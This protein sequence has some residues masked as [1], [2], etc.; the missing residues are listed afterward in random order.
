MIRKESLTSGTH[1]KIESCRKDYIWNSIAGVINALEAVV[2]SMVVTRLGQ[3]SDAGILSLAFAAG[4]VMLT[5]GKFGVRMFQVTDVR[6]EYSFQL[7]LRHRFLTI[8]FMIL[9]LVGFLLY[10]GYS[11]GKRDAIILIAVIYMIEALEDCFWGKY[12]AMNKLYIGAQM[13]TTRW[14]AILAVF[15]IWML[16]THNMT[17]ALTAGA[18]TGL[19]V[20]LSWLI[21]LRK[22][23]ASE[24]SAGTERLKVQQ[25][26]KHLFRQTSPLFLAS[27]CSIFISNIPKFA[28]DRHMN[29]EIQACYGFVAMPV[30][31]IGLLNQFIYQPTVVRLTTEYDAGRID[32]FRRAVRKQM[33]IVAGLCSACV[34]GAGLIGIPCLSLIYHTDLTGYWREL[35]IL[36][37]AGG[38]LAISGYF[39]ILLV[40]MRKQSI[41][42]AG[43][44]GALILGVFIMNLS[45]RLA[46]TVG[47]SVGY[48]ILMLL[49]FGFYGL[50]YLKII[51]DKPKMDE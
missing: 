31:V 47:A 24:D 28:I 13:F 33:L 20:F 12:Q 21:V 43:Y 15:S 38:F 49:L 25:E 1:K 45:V 32:N 5:V 17:T 48:V 41:I 46:G 3:L 22:R 16:H 37:F 23:Y 34:I 39:V 30:F 7:Y 50:S 18:V 8:G 27:F 26:L 9:T 11:A 42:L 36:Q 2:M 6:K 4:N 10:G 51:G 29:D 14:V 19:V 44:V 35:V 40:M